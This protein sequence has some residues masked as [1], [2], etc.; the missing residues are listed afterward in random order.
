MDPKI[1]MLTVQ[2]G[3]HKMHAE[4]VAGSGVPIVLMH[5]FPD[6]THLYDHLLPHLAGRQPVVRF[7]FLGWG[8]SDKPAGYPYTAA[9]Q[10]G[11][12][13]AVVD[14]I[15]EHVD[16]HQ[17]TLV[18][19]DA[20]GPPAIDWALANPGRV[21]MLVLLNT[22]YHWTPSLRRPPA[23]ALYSTPLIRDIARA[24]VRRWPQLDWRLYTWQVGAFIHDAEV[25]GPLVAQLYE[26]FIPARPAFWRLNDDLLGTVLTHRRRIPDLRRFTPPVRVIFGVRDRYLNPRVAR[27]FAALFPHSEL[28]LLD[29]AGHFVQ[30]DRAQQV[31]DLILAE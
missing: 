2:R 20:S 10:V 27:E 16:T 6:N 23:I 14:A 7:D 8:R 31:A 28:H 21:A 15:S 17:L 4:M 25:R 30:V 3:Q 1:D 24:L 26:Q 13:A 5:G 29:D 12:L 19:H 11:D 9:N 18:A 22:Y